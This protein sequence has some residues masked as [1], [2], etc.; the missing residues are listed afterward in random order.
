V[1]RSKHAIYLL[2]GEYGPYQEEI[3]LKNN[4]YGS[5]MQYFYEHLRV[6]KGLT[7]PSNYSKVFNSGFTE[8]KKV[9]VV[10]SKLPRSDISL[11]AIN[12]V[13]SGIDFNDEVDLFM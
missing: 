3:V 11:K 4:Y 9:P 12:F 8:E 1:R 7:V 6:Y 10:V 2:E 5:T 13:K